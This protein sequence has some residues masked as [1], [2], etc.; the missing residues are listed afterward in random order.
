M[1]GKEA[2]D[3]GNNLPRDGCFNC[4]VEDGWSCSG[5]AGGRSTCTS[6]AAFCGNSK[7]EPAIG[8]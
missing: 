6:N 7:Y 2:C 3:D 8:E 5:F 4:L 1:A